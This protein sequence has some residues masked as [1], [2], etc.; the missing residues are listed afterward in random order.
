MWEKNKAVIEVDAHK[1]GPVKCIRLHP[2]HRRL[3]S[4]GGDGRVLVWKMESADPDLEG[5]S[6]SFAD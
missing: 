4:C 6:L 5:P 3:L 1:K 2:D